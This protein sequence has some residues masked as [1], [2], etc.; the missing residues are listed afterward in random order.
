M[1]DRILKRGFECVHAKVDGDQ[2]VL[3]SGANLTGGNSGKKRG[4]RGR[5]TSDG[6]KICLF[7]TGLVC[8]NASERCVFLVG[9]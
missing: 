8:P 2:V 3:E 7:H 9:S 6:R 5:G 4:S 1:F